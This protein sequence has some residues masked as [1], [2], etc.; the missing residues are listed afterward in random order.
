MIGTM[1]DEPF[2]S[3]L[4]QGLRDV[5]PPE[6]AHQ[7]LI[8]ERL[9]QGFSSWGYQ[10]VDPPLVEFED[11]LLEGPGAKMGV[12]TFRLMDP[13]S[14]RMMG[15]RADITPQ[16]ARIVASR[17]AGAP[18]PL[19]LFYAGQI[20]RVR[21]GQLRPERQFLQTGIELIGCERPE[22]DAEV[23]L[24]AA[25][26]LSAAGVSGLSVD[27]SLP[28]VAREVISA[29]APGNG[30]ALLR[31]A[32]DRKDA[33]AVDAFGSP[34]ASGLLRAR[35]PVTQAVAALERLPLPEAA[36]AECHRLA[37]VATLLAAA[38]PGL[39]VTADPAEQRGFEYQNGLCFTLFAPGARGEIGRGGR[40]AAG[41]LG[42]SATGFSLYTDSLL[43]IV[44]APVR[45]QRIYA[46]HGASPAVTGKLRAEG[47]ITVTG[48][49]PAADPAAEARRL[50]CTHILAETGP[51]P[52]ED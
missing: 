30:A 12:Q 32:M 50:G 41:P 31:A 40:Y 38:A 21:G 51:V 15:A 48:L 9:A 52:V 44:P 42:E 20:L 47:R 36:V 16:I 5:L 10:R 35:G 1:G 49:A 45:P 18:R 26:V 46:P 22:A 2:P 34:A 19:R 43:R 17:L 29:A 33:A 14:Q 27:I 28:A 8:L 24:V 4:P 37:A 25:E 13:L 3:L 7:S 23:I 39:A 6:A 11:T